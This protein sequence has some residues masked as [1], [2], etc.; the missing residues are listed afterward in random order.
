MDRRPALLQA[1]VVLAVGRDGPESPD[2]D[3]VGGAGHV[4]TTATRRPSKQRPQGRFVL[5][6][7]GRSTGQDES[8]GNERAT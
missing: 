6:G 7:N 3:A 1:L 8:D 5:R 2:V 4:D